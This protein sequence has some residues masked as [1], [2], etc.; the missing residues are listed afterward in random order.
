MI[1]LLHILRTFLVV[2]IRS[3]ESP[4]V[5]FIIRAVQCACFAE[6]ETDTEFLQK[7]ILSFFSNVIHAV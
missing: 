2:C 4:V 5:V 1:V 7:T 3:G 6:R